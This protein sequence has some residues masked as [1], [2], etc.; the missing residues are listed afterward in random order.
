MGAPDLSISQLCFYSCLKQARTWDPSLQSCNAC[1]W[2][3]LSWNNKILRNYKGLKI[4]ACMQLGQIL[5]KR[6]KKKKTK[7]KTQQPILKSQEQKQCTAHIP[8]IPL[9]VGKPPRLHSSLTL[10]HTLMSPHTRNKLGPTQEGSSKE[11]AACSCSPLRQQGSHNLAWMSGLAP[12]QF[13]LIGEG[14]EPWSVS[15]WLHPQM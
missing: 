13:L 4:T 5:D 1:T 8:C 2:T 7:P 6:Y 12:S 14:Q 3:N 10:G 9:G 15:Y 11:P